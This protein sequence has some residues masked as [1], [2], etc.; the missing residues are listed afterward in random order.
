MMVAV[1][2]KGYREQQTSQMQDTKRRNHQEFF[3]REKEFSM[4]IKAKSCKA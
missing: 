2:E 3:N 4:R 1:T